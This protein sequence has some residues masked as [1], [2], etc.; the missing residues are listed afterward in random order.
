MFFDC[1]VFVHLIC[2][3]M[4][5]LFSANMWG[6]R[7]LE[8]VALGLLLVTAIC[9]V[10]HV[11]KV[12]LRTRNGAIAIMMLAVFAGLLLYFTIRKTCPCNKYHLKPHFY[13][14]KLGFTG[15]YLFFLFLLQNI[16][17]GYSQSIF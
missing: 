8:S 17:C 15:V 9:L 14:A 1:T 10:L 11:C 3:N 5:L 6:T 12:N 16:D 7:V 2:I 4:L 13:I